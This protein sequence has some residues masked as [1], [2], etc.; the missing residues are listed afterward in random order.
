MIAVRRRQIRSS[1]AY[2]SIN[3]RSCAW[4]RT[5]K[6]PTLLPATSSTMSHHDD[7]TISSSF[8]TIVAGVC[9]DVAA[10]SDVQCNVAYHCSRWVAVHHRCSAVVNQSL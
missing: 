3:G 6:A 4:K 2:R 5:S 8:R 9:H 7:V 1:I 10:E